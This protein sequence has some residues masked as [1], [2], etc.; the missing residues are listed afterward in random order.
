VSNLP[1]SFVLHLLTMEADVDPCPNLGSADDTDGL[2]SLFASYAAQPTRLLAWVTAHWSL[3]RIRRCLLQPPSF[4]FQ[5][6][7]RIAAEDLEDL[8]SFALRSRIGPG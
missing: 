4:V 7:F 3:H 2:S 6:K 5:T 8:T 1:G